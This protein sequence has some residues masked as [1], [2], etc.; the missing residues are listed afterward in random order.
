MSG[1]AAT[2]GP[3]WTRRALAA[4]ALSVPARSPSRPDRADGVCALAGTLQAPFHGVAPPR[5]AAA[6][7]DAAVLRPSFHSGGHRPTAFAPPPPGHRR[8]LD[9]CPRRHHVPA[10]GRNW[11]SAGPMM[12]VPAPAPVNGEKTALSDHD[13]LT[14]AAPPPRPPLMHSGRRKRSSTATVRLIVKRRWRAP[15]A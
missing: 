13:K 1:P 7:I 14:G 11:S 10:P 9:A 8:R 15:S 5:R 4:V 3:G 6:S 2:C 12:S